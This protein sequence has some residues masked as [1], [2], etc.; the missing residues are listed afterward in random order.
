MRFYLPLT[1]THG[2]GAGF[3]TMCLVG[4][5]TFGAVGHPAEYLTSNHP[6]RIWVTTNDQ[7]V[8]VMDAPTLHGDTLAG[9]VDGQYREVPLSHAALVQAHHP[10]P[11]R[12]RFLVAAAAGVATV[13]V[14]AAETHTGPTCAIL[15][16]YH[17][18]CPAVP[19]PLGQ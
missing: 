19:C 1:R 8:F 6:H 5:T 4:C 15:C 11:G 17:P 7:T 3:L 12:T 14:I 18:G 2:I 9:M 16:P 13:A 10:A